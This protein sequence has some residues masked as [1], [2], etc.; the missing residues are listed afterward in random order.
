M[1]AEFLSLA[2]SDPFRDDGWLELWRAERGRTS[3]AIRLDMYGAGEE[4]PDPQTWQIRCRR[5]YAWQLGDA[6]LNRAELTSDHVLL[7][8]YQQDRVVRGIKGS[9]RDVPAAIAD[10]VATHVRIAD[11]WLPF[12]FCF[13]SRLTIAELLST[14][15]AQMAAGPCDLIS[16]YTDLINAHGAE[17]YEISRA[18]SIESMEKSQTH[19][20]D[21]IELLILGDTIWL[22][23]VGFSAE[24]LQSSPA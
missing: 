12:G 22:I 10:L 3:A 9:V 17:T 20:T 18:P 7:A 16:F 21:P 14:L 8:A 2:K 13:N 11:H 5:L 23:G 24:R 6:P 15:A 19:E 1:L 4:D